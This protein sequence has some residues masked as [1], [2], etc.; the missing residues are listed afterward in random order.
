MTN[1]KP[2][3]NIGIPTPPTSTERLKRYQRIFLRVYV[4]G[5]VIMLAF[6]Y[7]CYFGTF[8]GKWGWAALW[9]FS[10]FG[11]ITEYIWQDN[12]V[13]TETCIAFLESI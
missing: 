3:T 6:N 12:A 11:Y 5:F 9:P 8:V 2:T 1:N 10:V 13:L 7:T 4:V